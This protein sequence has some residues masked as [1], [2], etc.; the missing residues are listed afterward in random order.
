ME[1]GDGW[2][3]FGAVRQRRANF[4]GRGSDLGR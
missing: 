1:L 2:V 4:V 3:M